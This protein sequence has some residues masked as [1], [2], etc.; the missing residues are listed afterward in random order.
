MEA[1]FTRLETALRVTGAFPP[2]DPEDP[3]GEVEK[4]PPSTLLWLLFLLAQ[5]HDRRRNT[6]AALQCID[7]AI[8]HT[9]TVADLYLVKGRILKHGG[10]PVGAAELADE[11]RS[12]D[13]ADRF[14]N[15]EAVKRMLQADQVAL[16]ERT[17]GLFT[18]DGEQADTLFEMHCMWYELACGD[19]HVRQGAVGKALKKYLATHKHYSDM[20]ED[21]FDFHT[22]CLRKMTLRAYVAMFKWA[23]NLHAHRYFCK[24]A[25]GAI[26]CYLRLHDH[27]PSKQ[28]EEE[29]AAMAALSAADRKK[30]R[31]KQ[32][33][34]E[35]RAKK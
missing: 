35:A 5:H 29:E 34:A 10:D 4:E 14:L 19:S 28:A 16:A 27:P 12:M 2:A 18:R 17:A 20:L 22:Y 23:D 11:A 33:K 3:A 24:G 30:L 26:R 25:H 8:L 15:S 13:L 1:V 31:Q 6:H 32:R 9:P 21:Q 7:E